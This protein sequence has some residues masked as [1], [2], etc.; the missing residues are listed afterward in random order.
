M[1]KPAKLSYLSLV[2]IVGFAASVGYHYVQGV[3]FGRP[4][5]LNTFLFDPAE[6][7]GDFTDV[8][9]DGHT[10]NPY[11]E[12]SSAQFPLLALVGFALSLLPKYADIAFLAIVTALFL[13]LSMA[14]LRL[15][16]WSTSATH[17]LAITLLSYP[18]LFAVD[19]GNFELLVFVL[20][21]AFLRFFTRG[22][23]GWSA[24]FLGLAIALKVYPVVLLVLY[25]PASRLRAA[26]VGLVV[27]AAATLGSLLCFKGGL[28]AN[29]SYLLQAGFMQADWKFIEFTSFSSDMVQRG[30]SLLTFIKVI[31]IE[32]GFIRGMGSALFTSRY[33]VSAIVIGAGAMIYTLFIEKELWKRTA[34]LV[35]VMLL[36]PPISADYKLLLI[37]LPLFLFINSDA[38]SRLDPAFLA[39]FGLLIVP[40]SYYYLPTVISESRAAHD[41]SI[42]VPANVI[43]LLLL[44]LLIVIPGFLGRFRQ[45]RK[46]P[47]PVEVVSMGE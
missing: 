31:S 28:W 41:I 34:I 24:L 10:L 43:L 20:L 33:M 29:V 32:T 21:L 25:L 36:L 44:G 6:H 7:G 9:R 27:A 2:L 38:R 37:Y 17:V 22:Q 1:D 8:L 40:K 11:L 45:P 13:L 23:Y 30:V 4:Y 16:T 35:L 5:P 39:I 15:A 3:Y 12:Y 26:V 42:A 18:F 47:A 19:R 46:G 14:S